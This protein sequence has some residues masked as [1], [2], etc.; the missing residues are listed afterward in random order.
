MNN[1][2]N[3]FFNSEPLLLFAVIGLGYLFGQ[4]KI[5]GFK[6][7]ISG[8]L[9][10]GLL[11]GG[12]KPEGT[13]PF[14][15]APQ[16]REVGL[17][18]FVYI[19]GLTSG[20]GFFASFRKRGVKFNLIVF[21]ALV[22]GAALTLIIGRGFKLP[23]GQIAGVYCGGLTNTP[24][25]AAVTELTKT[26]NPNKVT[27]PAIGYS[28]AYP[29]GVIGGLL[30]FHLFFKIFSKAFRNE[31]AL[32]TGDKG[33]TALIVQNFVIKNPA[34][35]GKVIGELRVRD[36]TGVIISRHKRD[37]KIIIPTKYT[38]LNEGDIIV[39]VGKSEDIEKAKDYFG[40]ISTE[41]FEMSENIDMRRILVSRRELVGKKIEE[42]GIDTKFNAQITRLRRADIEIIPSPE[43]VLEL[44]DRL[45][46]VMPTEK[47]EEVSKFFGD[48]VRG[49]SELDYT[50]IT[51]GIS[52]GVLI[53]MIPI[54]IPGGTS[55]KLGFA[56]GPLI[57]G[58]I[59]GRLSRTGPVVWSIPL[60]SSQALSHIGLLIF[61]AGVGITSGDNFFA[62]L[63]NSGWQLLVLGFFT[64]SITTFLTLF[65]LR[66]LGKASVVDSLGATSGMQTQPATLACAYQLTQSN[67][68]Y[69]A[70]AT[71]Y[72]VS[73]IGKILLA[74]LIFILGQGLLK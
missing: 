9:F 68:T 10:V 5:K 46:V 65:L 40:D 29:Y 30:A 44:G 52:L 33:K 69:V 60:E 41:S 39:T 35:F 16:I 37:N 17:I 14:H 74:Q 43:T 64:T 26:F 23:I 11:F 6:L 36:K 53:G 28:L 63:T 61:L 54:P 32:L 72:P 3:I 71:T 8:V 42:L 12:W 51:L 34:L 2:R 38:T 70:Y 59:L 45:R 4:L 73:M 58:L 49:I 66:F 57:V 22:V 24:A 47:I 15:I 7:G 55:V 18:L 13:E 21:S 50:A 56:G 20:P 25:L 1:F 48:S 27:D 62:S 31:T 19:V 67:D